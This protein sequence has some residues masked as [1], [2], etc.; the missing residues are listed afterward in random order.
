MTINPSITQI[1]EKVEEYE[2]LGKALAYLED[3]KDKKIIIF[4]KTKKSADDLADKLSEKGIASMSFHGDKPQTTRDYI[5]KSF[6]H[7]KSGVLVATDVAARGLDVSDIDIVMNFDFPGDIDSYIHR[8]GRTAR[9]SKEGISISYFTDE[10]KNLSRKLFKVMKTGQ[11]KIPDWLQ[12]LAASTP[13]GSSRQSRGFGRS[14]GGG[15]FRGG[16]GY[17]HHEFGGGSRR[18]GYGS[19]SNSYGSFGGGSRGGS[20]QS[21]Y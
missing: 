15:G 12:A 16:R 17:D 2:K 6:K 3:K 9:G 11:Q 14:Y 20:R 18:G 5:L 4:T 19:G 7:T 1:V 8:I 10:N 21:D 13:R